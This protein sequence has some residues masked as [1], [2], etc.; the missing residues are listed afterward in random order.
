MPICIYKPKVVPKKVPSRQCHQ[1]HGREII[2]LE[3]QDVGKEEED[4]DYFKIKLAYNGV[5]H[6]I[7]IVP[8]YIVT[9]LEACGHVKYY[10]KGAKDFPQTTFV[11][12]AKGVQ[13]LQVSSMCI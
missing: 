11:P 7:P 4:S 2:Y 12:L 13:L 8:S 5:H 1:E 3:D 10:T 6:Y 9:F